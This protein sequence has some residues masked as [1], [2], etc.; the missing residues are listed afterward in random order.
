MPPCPP[1]RG[2]AVGHLKLY[3]NMAQTANTWLVEAMIKWLIFG[4]IGSIGTPC[5]DIT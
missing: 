2:P 4:T 1:A 3:K 5:C